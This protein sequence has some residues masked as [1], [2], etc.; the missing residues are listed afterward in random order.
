MAG[1]EWLSYQEVADMLNVEMSRL[2]AAVSLLRR[3]GSV[4]TMQNPNNMRETLI[5]SSGIDAIKQ[6]LRVNG[7]GNATA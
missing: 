4:R 5:H 6:A 3:V 2:Y 1:K 7:S